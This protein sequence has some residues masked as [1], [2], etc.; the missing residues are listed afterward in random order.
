MIRIFRILKNGPYE[1]IL[2]ELPIVGKVNLKNRME[3]ELD[4]FSSDKI[5]G[6]WLF[7]Y[8]D[9]KMA[10]KQKQIT[11]NPSINVL[12][13]TNGC[14]HDF[15][16]LNQYKYQQNYRTVW[17]SNQKSDPTNLIVRTCLSIK[18]IIKHLKPI[19]FE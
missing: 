4:L 7:N 17:T 13:G 3:I 11:K 5:I 8:I 12:Y 9:L 1:H 18:Q 14:L 16:Y 2:S 6:S 19:Q 15:K 10:W